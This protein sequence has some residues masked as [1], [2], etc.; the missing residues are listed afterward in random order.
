M[1]GDLRLSDDVLAA[2]QIGEKALRKRDEFVSAPLHQPAI[3]KGI[4]VKRA[5]MQHGI[6]PILA[7]HIAA[8][9]IMDIAASSEV[10]NLGF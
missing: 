1:D 3:D 2:A 9:R 10:T 6:K 4:I 5:T 7:A 8:Q